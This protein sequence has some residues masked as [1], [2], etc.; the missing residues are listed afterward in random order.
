LI[1]Q[2]RVHYLK[3]PEFESP[4]AKW[5]AVHPLVMQDGRK[6]GQEDLTS[7]FASALFERALL[8]G[9]A[10]LSGKPLFKMIR[11]DE[12]G[13]EP[14]Q[15]HAELKG[16]PM[17]D[18][19]PREPLTSFSIRH[20]VGYQDP[21]TDAEVPRESRIG[22]GLPESL[23]AYI[24]RD[25]LRYFKVKISG[26][27]KLDRERLAG[28]WDVLPKRPETGI[29]LDA[30]EAYTDLKQFESFV[31]G[32]KRHESGLFDHLLYIEQPL[33]RA[34]AHDP[35]AQQAIRNVAR[36]KPVIIDESDGT[37]DSFK[38][39]YALGY[40][41]TSHK[42]CKG[43]FK[44]LLNR[45]LAIEFSRSGAPVFLS[46]EDL[47]NLPVVPLQQDFA[48]LS[49]LGLDHCERNGH[50]YNYGLSFLSRED[51][52]RAVQSHPDLYVERG[53]ESFLRIRDGAVQCGS[54]QCAGF[55]VRDEPDWA[56]MDDLNEWVRRRFPS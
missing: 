25:G 31:Q 51:K 6:A 22:D 8:D 18:V 3:Q 38:R 49:I 32:M 41:G 10:R 30:N 39:A 13:I 9:V 20:T 7:S 11:D 1:N 34:L 28:I 46:A 55:G 36:L 54:L 35:S 19:L 43:F 21:L 37:L 26:D 40:S 33:P 53:E 42:N 50:H 45:A 17:S 23:A 27:P 56:S 15:M 29:T 47:Q 14:E 2:A 24:Q 16:V 4:F 52:L 12:L 48:A 5:Q 44:S